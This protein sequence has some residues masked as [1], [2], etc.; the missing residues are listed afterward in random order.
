MYHDG[1]PWAPGH[2]Q[3][4][5][6]GH[7]QPPWSQHCLSWS[8]MVCRENLMLGY[9]LLLVFMWRHHFPKLKITI[10]LSF[11]SVSFIRWYKTLTFLAFKT[12][13]F[14]AFKLN[15]VPHF[16]LED[17]WIPKFMHCMTLKWPRENRRIIPLNV[18]LSVICL[19]TF[20]TKTQWR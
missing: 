3:D 17:I 6:T 1:S 2:G 16:V 13:H 4:G 15:K 19:W 9:C 18:L 5:I 12:W 11:R 8:H 10:L 20:N 7:G 14:T